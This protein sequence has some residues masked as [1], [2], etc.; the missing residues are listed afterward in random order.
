VATGNGLTGGPITTTGT[1]SAAVT[2]SS[3]TTAYNVLSAD[4]G[5]HFDNIG[6]AG[7]VNFSLPAAAA[8]LF[9]AFLCHAAHAIVVTANGTDVISYGAISSSA[10]GT[11][12]AATPFAFVALES[13][14]TGQWVASSML[15]GWV[16]A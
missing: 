13:H 3:K 9:Y 14:A 11:I 7:S 4:A 16:A 2:L 12:T 6:A 10:G 1:I 15:G 8:G 5:V